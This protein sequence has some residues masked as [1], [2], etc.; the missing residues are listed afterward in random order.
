MDGLQGIDLLREWKLRSAKIQ[1]E[2]RNKLAA[3]RAKANRT[4]QARWD[5]SVDV[6]DVAHHEG[7]VATKAAPGSKEKIAVLCHRLRNG[8]PLWH[9]DDPCDTT[10]PRTHI[11]EFGNKANAPRAISRQISTG[12]VDLSD[13]PDIAGLL[14]GFDFEE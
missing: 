14:G 2:E 4:K 13:A 12:R 1:R 3:K 8:L 11:N 9:E 7:F 6:P 5:D 10:S